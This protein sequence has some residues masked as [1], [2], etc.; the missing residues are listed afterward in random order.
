MTTEDR[1]REALR[2]RADEHRVNAALPASTIVKARAGRV[3]TGMLAVATVAALVVGGAAAIGAVREEGPAPRPAPAGAED[4]PEPQTKGAPFLLVG[5]A[6]WRVSRADQYSATIGEMT[7]TN[8]ERELELNWRPA[9]DHESFVEDRG[10]D[11]A[12]EWDVE[13]ARRHGTL[14][15]YEGTTDFTT[16]WLDG[17]LSLELRGVFP[18]VH[19][20]RAVAGTLDRVDEATWLAA[21]PASTV[22]PSERA[23]VVDSM[24][25]DLPVHPDANLEQF[26][27]ADRIS[28]RYQL[29]AR[30]TAAVACAWIGQWVEARATGDERAARLAAEAMSTSG[31]WPILQEMQS[32]GEWSEV[33]WDYADAMAGESEVTGGT[34]LSVEGSYRDALGCSG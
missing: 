33:V 24:V 9:S 12:E 14:F 18:D 27:R 11:A 2:R 4:T 5:H 8:G 19:A 6:G 3:A 30:V 16:L 32:Q 1:V 26:R 13:I 20:Y 7:F 34:E 21:M 23:A 22:V 31:A 25:E 28:D 10:F 29:G 15:R 17:D